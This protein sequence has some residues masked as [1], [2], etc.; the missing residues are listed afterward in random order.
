MANG[1]SHSDLKKRI[2]AQAMYSRGRFGIEKVFSCLE[3]MIPNGATSFMRRTDP[4][5][6]NSDTN[7]VS[8]YPEKK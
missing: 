7:I 2:E 1:A 4:G 6:D 8:V 3:P 5:V